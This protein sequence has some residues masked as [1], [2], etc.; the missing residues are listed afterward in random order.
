VAAVL[1]GVADGAAVLRPEIYLDAPG[2]LLV[3]EAELVDAGLLN[4]SFENESLDPWVDTPEGAARSVGEIAI[5][6]A[7]GGQRHA[8]L[9][10]ALGSCLT[11]KV[12]LRGPGDE[13]FV[14]SCWVSGDDDAESVRVTV[15]A[16][17]LGFPAS[18]SVTVEPRSWSAVS[19]P[20]DLGALG[21]AAECEVT[22][23][24]ELQE[25]GAVLVDGCQL[26]PTGLRDARFE[27]SRAAMANSAWE[28]LTQERPEIVSG[29]TVPPACGGRTLVR[30]PAGVRGCGFRQRIARAPIVGDSLRLALWARAPGGDPDARLHLGVVTSRPTGGP[31]ERSEAPMMLSAEW[32]HF[33]T[34]LDVSRAGAKAFE[35]Y[36]R[37]GDPGR[38]V[39]VAGCSLV[40][41]TIRTQTV[42]APSSGARG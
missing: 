36:F 2:E 22:V 12:M 31:G 25:K 38:V 11:Q 37:N 15:S 10:G 41:G 18:T 8:H 42:A 40:S 17:R 6:A 1:D 35:V 34:T 32:R 14:F 21:G 33:S 4:A 29:E 13:T 26:L 24:I 19:V 28:S 20:F 9:R 7:I 30:L 5:P 3:D 39:E 27:S 23:G 16:G